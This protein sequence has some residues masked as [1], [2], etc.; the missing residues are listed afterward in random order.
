MPN[1]VAARTG[2]KLEPKWLQMATDVVVVVVVAACVHIVLNTQEC[3]EW[4]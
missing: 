4:L 2:R 3:N 1:Q